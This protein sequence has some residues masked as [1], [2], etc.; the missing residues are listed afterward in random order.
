[1]LALIG[2]G[3]PEWRKTPYLPTGFFL[4]ERDSELA[5]LRRGDDSEV[6]AYSAAG[7]GPKEV[8]R[9]AWMTLRAEEGG[10]P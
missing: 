1:V 6:T 7:A 8:V 5:V 4:D 9:R 2:G 3:G 10:A